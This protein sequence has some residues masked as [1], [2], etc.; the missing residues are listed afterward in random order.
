M[1]EK[2]GDLLHA[3]GPH[4]SGILLYPTGRKHVYTDSTDSTA[5]CFYVPHETTHGAIFLRR[6][7]MTLLI[8][9]MF[10]L[11]GAAQCPARDALA[12]YP[13]YL[14]ISSY[15][16]MDGVRRRHK[17]SQQPR[18]KHTKRSFSIMMFVESFSSGRVVSI[19]SRLVPT[20]R[21]PTVRPPRQL[22]SLILCCRCTALANFYRPQ[23]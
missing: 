11:I 3:R 14:P 17:D 19:C 21:V 18:E 2:R 9:W 4:F 20:N 16:S 22:L 5:S 15:S 10:S 6:R 12:L 23:Q 13:A 1:L 7:Y 8:R